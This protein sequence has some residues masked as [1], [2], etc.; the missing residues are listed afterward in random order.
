MYS[1]V[2]ENLEKWYE[3]PVRSRHSNPLVRGFRKFFPEKKKIKAVDGISFKVNAG[4]IFGLLGSNGA[5]KTTTLQILS[6]LVYPDRG[7][8][9]VEGFS[10]LENVR[11]IRERINVVFEDKLLYQK[12]TVYEN[13]DFYARLY[14]VKERDGRIKKLLKEVDLEKEALTFVEDLSRGMKQKVAVIRGAL[15]SPRVL[16]LDEPTTGLDPSAARMVRDFIRD[17][18]KKTGATI[19]LTTHY[20]EEADLLCDRIAIMDKG[21]IVAL[22]TPNNLKKLVQGEDVLVVSFAGTVKDMKDIE[23]VE[24]VSRAVCSE[25]VLKAYVDDAEKRMD[26][27]LRAVS[28]AGAKIISAGKVKPSLEDVFIYLT[29]RMPEGV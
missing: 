16:F 23:R 3:K 8:V 17:I 28:S 27:L 24:G 12:L 11:P 25:N 6:T 29:G 20:M 22:D 15:T 14:D 4:E 1:I 5:G 18:R 7:S 21:K 10:V 9:F 13:L 19:I 26:G 2:V